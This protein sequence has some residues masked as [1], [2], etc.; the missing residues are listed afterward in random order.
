MSAFL[1]LQGIET[2]AVRME[3]HVENARAVAHFLRADPRIERVDYVGFPDHPHHALA[4]KY[5]RGRA[6]SLL[7]LGVAGAWRRPRRFT[8][9]SNLSSGS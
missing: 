5:L 1:L 6:P 3:R 8:T 4:L 7:T 9:R 2:L